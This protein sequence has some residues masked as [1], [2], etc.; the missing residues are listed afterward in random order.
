MYTNIADLTAW[1]NLK[2]G[3]WF[4]HDAPECTERYSVGERTTAGWTT[5]CSTIWHHAAAK[6]NMQLIAKLYNAAMNSE[7]PK[8][9]QTGRDAKK[10]SL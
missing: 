2:V 6:E 9:L 8:P 7:A 4:F 3:D 5:V 1:R 10:E